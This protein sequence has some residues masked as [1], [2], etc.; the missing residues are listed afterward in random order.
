VDYILLISY[1]TNDKVSILNFNDDG[2]NN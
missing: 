2:M 1:L